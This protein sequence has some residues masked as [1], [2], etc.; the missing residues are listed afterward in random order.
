MKSQVID[1]YWQIARWRNKN[2]LQ[3]V[4]LQ[5]I[6]DWKAHN[7]VA[8]PIWELLRKAGISRSLQTVVWRPCQGVPNVLALAQPCS[9]SFLDWSPTGISKGQGKIMFYKDLFLDRRIVSPKWITKQKLNSSNE[10]EQKNTP[11]GKRTHKW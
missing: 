8:G 4:Y 2:D 7:H 11:E 6:P 3:E 10:G 9:Q 5:E 1:K